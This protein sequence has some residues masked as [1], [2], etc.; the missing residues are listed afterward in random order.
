MSL[1]TAITAELNLSLSEHTK[2]ETGVPFDLRVPEWRAKTPAPREWLPSTGEPRSQEKLL[3]EL[4]DHQE[5]NIL[6]SLSF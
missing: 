4:F 5:E 1:L 2:F 6:K 3:A